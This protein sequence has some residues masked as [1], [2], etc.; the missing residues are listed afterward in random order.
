MTMESFAQPPGHSDSA[1]HRAAVHGQEVPPKHTHQADVAHTTHN[2]EHILHHNSHDYQHVYKELDQLRKQDHGSQFKQDMTAVNKKLHDDGLLPH[3]HIIEDDRPGKHNRTDHGYSVVADDKQ[4]PKGNHT[5]VSTSHDA[6][7][8]SNR[9][10]NA[11]R[12][13]HNKHG[14]YNGWRQS[15]EGHGGA[16]G[17]HYDGAVGGHVPEGARKD[18]IDKAL[19]LAGVPVTPENEAAVNKIVTRESGWN[20]NV[21][22]N[23]DSNAR[24]GHPSTGLMQTI[25][26]TF[27]KYAL[28]GM[29]SNI[30]DPLSNLVAGIRYAQARYSRG[31]RSGVA[32]VA[33]RPGGY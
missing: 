32:V 19:N 33:S 8:E 13:M 26:S 4:N 9:L 1:H 29:N 6:P 21:T 3:L 30:H 20:P 18:L 16:H 12:S 7:H 17:G 15:T 27:Q 31:D 2:I 25:P 24:A 11:Y 23:W 5:E 22:N 14:H 28:P 10:K